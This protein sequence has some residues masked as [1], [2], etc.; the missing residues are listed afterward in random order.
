MCSAQSSFLC[1]FFIFCAD[2]NSSFAKFL[3]LRGT[4]PD[5]AESPFCFSAEEFVSMVQDYSGWRDKKATTEAD[6]G[7]SY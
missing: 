3:K 6:N 4:W 5:K 7:P 1:A 2:V